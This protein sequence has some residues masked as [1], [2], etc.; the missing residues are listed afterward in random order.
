MAG[1]PKTLDSEQPDTRESYQQ[2]YRYNLKKIIAAANVE[3]VACK[4]AVANQ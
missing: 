4:S 3:R 1:K 2:R